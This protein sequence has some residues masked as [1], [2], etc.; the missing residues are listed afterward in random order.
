MVDRGS[1]GD[2]QDRI[3]YVYNS[4]VFILNSGANMYVPKVRKG[5]FKFWLGRRTRPIEGRVSRIKPTLDCR[6]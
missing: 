3:E 2:Y 1:I 5:F 4:V 6:R